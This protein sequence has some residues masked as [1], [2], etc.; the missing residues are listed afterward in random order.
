MASNSGY[1]QISIVAHWLAAVVVIALFLTHEDERGSAAYIF[2]ASGGAIVGVFLLWR[3]WH[4]LRGGLAQKPDQAP[5]L[6]LV[7]NIVIYGFLLAIVTVVLTGY[8]LPWS[9]G[10]PVE[11]LSLVSIPSPI[12]SNHTIH[13][14]VE[15]VHELS[16]QLFVPLLLLH[17]LGTAKHAFFDKDTIAARMFKSVIGGR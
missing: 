16:G 14:V 8:F 5:I 2:H 1:S 9:L 15:E 7:S 3:V 4:R 10:R 6:N 12:G 13:E 17:I 11:I